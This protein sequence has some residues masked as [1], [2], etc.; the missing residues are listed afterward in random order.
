[1]SDEDYEVIIVG[2]SYAG[3]S[4][5]LT[6]GR[7]LRKVLVIDKGEPCNRFTPHSHNF[8]TRDGQAPEDI[9]K[10]AVSDVLK[11]ETVRLINDYAVEAVVLDQGFSIVTDSGSH[12]TS[13]KLVLATGLKDI[14]P[15][16]N[17]FAECWGKS[18]VH[19]PYCHGY[20]EKGRSTGILANGEG[21]MH[22]APLV[23]NLT[24]ELTIFTNGKA[25]FAQDELTLLGQNEITIDERPL[26]SVQQS[27]GRI[28]ALN[29]DDRQQV[30][31]EVLY[32]AVPFEINGRLHSLL[33][34][35][36]DER[37][38]IKVDFAQK[39]NVKDVFACGDNS[40]MRSLSKAIAAGTMVG[41]MINFELAN[42]K[43][44]FPDKV[45]GD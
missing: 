32:C 16:I 2:G 18:I 8:L 14:L 5:A 39:T 27:N 44:Q 25:E 45:L 41:A 1:M 6:L 31:L 17:G 22:Y 3:L 9:S 29:F 10:R 34:C 21:A 15:E 28:E 24:G 7:S 40:G 26:V 42:A 20:E 4:A 30:P 35:E 12:Y 23:K 33:D 11:Y 13:Q 43:F 37:G 38:L 36:L 19:C